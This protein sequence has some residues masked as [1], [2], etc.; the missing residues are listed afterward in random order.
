MR[1]DELP[2]SS[3]H[4]WSFIFIHVLNIVGFFCP[5]PSPECILFLFIDY[6]ILENNS[7]LKAALKYKRIQLADFR[8]VPT[9]HFGEKKGPG[10]VC[11]RRAVD[12]WQLCNRKRL[13]RFTSEA[14][15]PARLLWLSSLRAASSGVR[16]TCFLRFQFVEIEF[17]RLQLMSG[18]VSNSN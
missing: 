5:L 12:L 10:P 6:Y 9:E 1:W 13:S 15:V 17:A 3:H 7:L 11:P 14:L 16:I 2:L 18:P 4:Y 8:T